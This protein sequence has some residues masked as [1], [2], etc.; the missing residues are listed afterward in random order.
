[1]EWVFLF[2]GHRSCLFLGYLLPPFR[3]KIY[4]N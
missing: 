3:G 4:A 1:V 2:A